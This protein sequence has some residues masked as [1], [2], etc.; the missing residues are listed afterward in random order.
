M[1]G[2]KRIIWHWTAGSYGVV[3]VELRHYHYVI[4]QNENIHD[5]HKPPESNISTKGGDYVAHTKGTNTGSIGIAIDAMHGAKHTP[6][7]WGSHPMT[8]GQVQTLVELSADLHE[9]YG[10]PVTR[11]TMLSHAEVEPTL[12]IRQRGKWDIAVLPGMNRPADPVVI[13]DELRR[14]VTAEIARRKKP[15]RLP[16]PTKTNPFAALIAAIVEFLKGLGR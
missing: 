14:R 10:I 13:G 4:D 7:S 11:R 9:T 6:F 2:L 16:L 12:G 5:G 3:D 15:V 8:E 1:A